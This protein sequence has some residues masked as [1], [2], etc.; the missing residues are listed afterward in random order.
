MV[1]SAAPV[2]LPTEHKAQT[3]E[4]PAA[5]PEASSP[6]PVTEAATTP[7]APSVTSASVPALPPVATVAPAVAKQPPTVPAGLPEVYR[8]RTSH[9]L[10]RALQAVEKAVIHHGGVPRNVARNVTGGLAQ[11][12]SAR[13]GGAQ[14]VE[15]YP[16]AMFVFISERAFGK[17][18]AELAELLRQ[19][20]AEGSLR[21]VP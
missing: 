20:Q 8:A 14:G 16:R 10:L 15:V 19:A 21:R 4:A 13:L 17:S 6:S 18:R 3:L 1:A 9:E 7:A 11:D 5:A 12:L 2:D